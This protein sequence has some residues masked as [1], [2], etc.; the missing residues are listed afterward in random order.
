MLLVMDSSHK[1]QL[2]VFP[3]K[4]VLGLDY[5]DRRMY[6]LYFVNRITRYDLKIRKDKIIRTR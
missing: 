6:G 5:E 1:V 4:E 3:E 2:P